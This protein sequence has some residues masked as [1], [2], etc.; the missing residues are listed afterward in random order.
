MLISDWI[1]YVCSS[2]LLLECIAVSASTG[3]IPSF[4]NFLTH[5]DP[6]IA[7]PILL[8]QHLP[9]AFMEFYAR[10]I[11]LMT[12][13]RVRVAEAGMAVEPHH[14]YLA[15]GD[16]HLMVVAHGRRREIALDRRPV[17]N[18]CCPPA[19]PTLALRSEVYGK[20]GVAVIM[21]VRIGRA[22]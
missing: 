12:Q 4:G 13:R 10:Q 18:G 5:L 1:S 9:D 2:D 21:S 7:A 15:P 6:R 17:E 14:I 3:V 20:G 11:G 8:T 16:A 22:A 19:D